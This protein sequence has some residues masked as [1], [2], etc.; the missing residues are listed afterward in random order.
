M[1]KKPSPLRQQYE[2]AK[3]RHPDMLLLF[4]VRDFYEFFNKDAETAAR[5]LGLTVT[6]KHQMLLAGFPRH[7]L[8]HYLRKLL[9]DGHKVAVC[10]QPE[11]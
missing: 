4:R 10:E 7:H 3:A 6:H 9:R 11:D 1:S 5:V 8:E 2:D